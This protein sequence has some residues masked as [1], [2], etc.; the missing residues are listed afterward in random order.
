MKNKKHKK[1]DQQ[2]K[3]IR[4]SSRLFIL[5]V[6]LIVCFFI[7]L[8]KLIEYQIIDYRKYE[9]LSTLDNQIIE[10]IPAAR[11]DILDRN[12]VCLATNVLNLSLVVS[13]NFPFITVKDNKK[14]AAKK[15]EQG[16]DI[17]LNLI[18]IL[19]KAKVDWD[20]ISPISRTKPYEF[21]DDMEVEVKKLKNALSQ[22]QY[23]NATDS[24]K[25]LTKKFNI[26]TVKYNKSQVRDI[27]VFRAN[28]LIKGISEYGGK[29]FTI[30]DNVEPDFLDKI[31]GLGDRLKGIQILET[32]KRIYPSGKFMSHF[33][34]NIGPI[35]KE[36][37][38]KYKQLGY[39]QDAFVGKF[40]VE[41][42]YDSVLKATNG[43]MVVVKDEEG[44][45][46]NK[47]FEKD[48]IPGKT[49]KLTIDFELQKGVYD[50]LEKFAKNNPSS[51]RSAKGATACVLNV[52]TGEILA[53]VSY[54]SY[55]INLYNSNYEQ[56]KADKLSPLKSRGLVELYRPGSSFKPFIA[57][58]GLMCGAI[59][60]STKF[61]CKDGI[62]PNM[63]CAHQRHRGG[64]IDIYSAIEKSCN[65]YFYQTGNKIGIETIDK[66]AP[67]FGYG[68]DTGLEIYSSKGRVTNPSKEFE[69]KYNAKYHIG[70]LW[71]TAI[72]QSETYSTVLQQAICQMTIANKGRRFAAHII[73]SIEDS[74]HKIL[75]KTKPK[76]MSDAKIS[77][78]AYETVV[79][80]MC[81]MAKSRE[82]LR[83]LDVAAKSGSPQYSFNKK[84][85]NAAGVGFYPTESP[86]IAMAVL[87]ENGR[88]GV[89]FF[90]RIVK[91][92]EKRKRGEKLSDE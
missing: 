69:K 16:N 31:S 72:G 14:T 43:K 81:M 85:T 33:I 70:D 4:C 52:K 21:L 44:N 63:K 51:Q 67:Y 55:D 34:G 42:K 79:K 71:Q 18:K 62:M 12:G 76:I 46:I 15:F 30:V 92:Y 88:R 48:P 8:S 68:T 6:F 87:I 64:M 80:G 1:I 7:A 39:P 77:N 22:Q 3:P 13:E 86:E 17:I 38:E 11:G 74:N 19:D 41:E 32:S 26:N 84:L 28:M 53:I 60:P 45:T 65:N 57:I 40:G 78:V 59:S 54:P 29:A 49:I 83:G 10:T 5:I 73:K 36:D 27:A 35:Y 9:K 61:L 91:L 47:Y 50:A 66:Y 25:I 58:T 20:K 75:K 37:Y 23:A 90:E 2:N 89:D 56:F 82:A 24:I